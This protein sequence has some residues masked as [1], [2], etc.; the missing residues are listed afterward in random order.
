MAGRPASVDHRCAR[1]PARKSNHV[2]NFAGAE[3]PPAP[4]LQLLFCMSV[5][6]VQSSNWHWLCV[7]AKTLPF[8]NWHWHYRKSDDRPRRWHPSRTSFELTG[9][10]FTCRAVSSPVACTA[11]TNPPTLGQWRDP[12]EELG[13]RRRRRRRVTPSEQEAAGG[14]WPL[15]TPPPEAL[16][17]R[18]R[19]KA[20]KDAGSRP[21]LA[22]R[23]D[24]AP[25]SQGMQRRR[26]RGHG[27]NDMPTGGGR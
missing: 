21:R 10:L 13:H 17:P 18:G 5:V 15:A 16:I 7:P 24:G 8:S 12:P 19:S 2:A 22:D 6:L 25:A 1:S 14:R 26:P 4:S 3:L 27:A 11:I 20:R 23:H 9:R